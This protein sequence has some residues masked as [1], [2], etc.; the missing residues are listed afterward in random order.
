MII[1]SIKTNGTEKLLA[2]AHDTK[3]RVTWLCDWN[4]IP[5]TLRIY[6]GPHPYA[7]KFENFKACLK[8]IFGM[9]YLEQAERV[10]S[11]QETISWMLNRKS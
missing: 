7:I 6:H 4:T 1:L 9:K 10:A 5:N 2:I 8:F 3:H 11:M